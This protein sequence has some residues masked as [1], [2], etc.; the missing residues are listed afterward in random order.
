[1]AAIV[2]LEGGVAAATLSCRDVL[3]N[4]DG[5]LIAMQI[6]LVR[7]TVEVKA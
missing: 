7:L 3:E 1:M 5:R 2:S 4:A 6:N